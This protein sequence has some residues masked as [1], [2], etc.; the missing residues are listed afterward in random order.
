MALAYEKQGNPSH[1]PLILIH[2]FPLNHQMWKYQLAGLSPHI[3]VFAPDLPGFGQSPL[4]EASPSLAA[5][6]DSMVDFMASRQIPRAVFGGC[7]MGGYILFDLWRKYPEK[8]AGL[9]LCDTRPEADTPEVREKRLKTISDIR[10]HGHSPLIMS[11]MPNLFSPQTLEKHPSLVEEVRQWIIANPT[12]GIIHAL[13]ALA[14]RSDSTSFLSRISTPTLILV[15]Q[16]DKLTPPES[17][18]ALQKQIPHSRL[19]II[20]EAGHLSPYEQPEFVNTA[21]LQYLQQEDFV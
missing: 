18:Q 15:G 9:I 4:L 3:Q 13:T 8:V 20:P 11:M 1:P 5:Y 21:I 7:S 6:T 17:A 16:E 2:A 12:E 10:T 19:E 14:S